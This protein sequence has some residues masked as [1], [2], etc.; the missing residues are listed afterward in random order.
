MDVELLYSDFRQ[1]VQS[2]LTR[3]VRD[4][5]VAEDLC[6][7]TFAKAL[8]AWDQRRSSADSKAWLYRIATNTAYDYLHRQ[9]I[10][11]RALLDRG[12][13]TAKGYD[14]ETW[15][16]DRVLIQSVLAELPDAYRVPL[17]MYAWGGYSTQEIAAALGCSNNCIK[18]RLHRARQRCQQLCRQ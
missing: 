12:L 10:T 11:A 5:A 6:Q 17:L 4:W 9:R 14:V 3:L 2:Y 8:R 16:D 13:Q 7:D 15:L 1:P 18:V